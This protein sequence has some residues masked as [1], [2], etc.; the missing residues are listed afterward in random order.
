MSKNTLESYLAA[1]KLKYETEKNGVFS[2]FLNAPSPASIRNL[3]L[4]IFKSASSNI[5]LEILNH[6]FDLKGNERDKAVIEKFDI[7]KFRPICNFFKGKTENPNHELL[8]LM[9]LLVNLESRPL[10]KYLKGET[11]KGVD[12]EIV[13]K[14]MGIESSINPKPR[15]NWLQNNIKKVVV[16]FLIS[17]L[18]LVGINHFTKSK[19][20]MEWVNNHYEEVDCDVISNRNGFLNNRFIYPKDEIALVNFKKIIPCDTTTFFKHKKPCIWYGK[21]V[22]GEYEYFTAPGLHPETGKTLKEI[23]WYIIEKHIKKISE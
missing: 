8:D 20:C 22:K 23:T 2:T 1:I 11:K 16:T 14:S 18:G 4:E 19:K 3:C 9:A 7:D 6:F 15:N 5:D 12:V 10:R 17:I 21:S 13:K